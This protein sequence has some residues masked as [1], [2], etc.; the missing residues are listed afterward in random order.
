MP[1]LKPSHDDGTVIGDTDIDP[2]CWGTA[3]ALLCG[4]VDRA[5]HE[6][7]KGRT[8]RLMFLLLSSAECIFCLGYTILLFYYFECYDSKRMFHW[9]FMCL[10]CVCFVNSSM[11][12]IR[13]YREHRLK[14]Q[15]AKLKAES[16]AAL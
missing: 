12:A 2:G 6:I 11:L 14:I 15:K 10:F 13:S 5:T 7:L 16:N 4:G 8:K 9:F 1:S 3:R